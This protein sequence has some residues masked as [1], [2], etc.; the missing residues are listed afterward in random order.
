VRLARGCRRY[1]WRR[2]A[3]P[4]M[5]PPARTT[6]ILATTGGNRQLE[7]FWALSLCDPHVTRMSTVV[8]RDIEHVS[9]VIVRIIRGSSGSPWSDPG[10]CDL[11]SAPVSLGIEFPS[12]ASDAAAASKVAQKALCPSAAA[13]QL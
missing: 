13:V 11:L 4:S 1:R 12:A 7:G 6:S 5:A 3:A 2:S 10:S 8:S 9:R